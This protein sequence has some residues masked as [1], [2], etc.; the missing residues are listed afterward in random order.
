MGSRGLQARWEGTAPRESSHC[1]KWGP[2][3]RSLMEAKLSLTPVFTHTWHWLHQEIQ[4]YLQKGS[5]IWPPLTTTATTLV[6]ATSIS[7]LVYYI[8]PRG[9]PY[10][11]SSSLPSIL[12]TA[13]IRT[14]YNVSQIVWCFWANPPMILHLKA[15]LRPP[16]DS[17]YL[18]DL[19]SFLL[20]PE[21]DGHAL[22]KGLCASPPLSGC[23]SHILLALASPPS[24]SAQLPALILL[25]T[26]PWTLL[27]G[28]A[29]LLLWSFSF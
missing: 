20:Q 15:H 19:L 21:H 23:S 14:M 6:P 13:A 28:L 8:P 29:L 3:T 25:P 18:C 12:S 10:L 24:I 9:P 5:R 4:T 1:H 17:C 16:W 22:S 2:D 7:H 26:V 11:S 27:S